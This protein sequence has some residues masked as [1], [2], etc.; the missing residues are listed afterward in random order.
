MRAWMLRQP[1]DIENRP[2]VVEDIAD[3]Q[4]GPGQVRLRVEVCGICRTDLHIAEGDIEGPE[5]PVIPGHQ[6]V[7][8]VDAVGVGA[9]E[10]LLGQR[11]GAY[12]LYRA[13][14][15]CLNC[16]R[17]DENLCEYASFTGFSVPGGFA[18][19]MVVYPGYTVPIPARLSPV[20]AA[21][22]LC[23]GIIGY[24]SFRLSEVRPGERLALFGFGASAHIVIQLAHHRGCEVVVYTRSADHQRMA[25]EMGAIWVGEAGEEQ[26]PVCDS[27]I[28][29]AP[30][31]SIVPHALRA[32]R[33][34][35]TVALN[36]VS[37]T[38]IPSLPYE[39]IYGERT[40]RSVAH[41]TRRDACE[42]MAAA[43][44]IPVRTRV[45]EYPFSELN[46]ALLAV[47]NSEIDGAAV[48]RVS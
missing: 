29:F 30:V 15:E 41:V 9:D 31:G 48:L 3:V 8:V 40:L 17:E 26:G 6:A 12:W 33:P 18:E 5:H 23:A 7:G 45:R 14:G 4:P 11:R 21:P 22:L 39:L 44:Q 1:A 24:R 38:D 16:L 19:A 42:F 34:G 20:Q 25:R 2:L 32:V 10:G 36:A 28:T 43:G 37:M 47:K 35:G 27:A 13:C 46:E